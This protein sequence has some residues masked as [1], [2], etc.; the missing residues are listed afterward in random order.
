MRADA[1]GTFAAV[2]LLDAKPK[3]NSLAGV[4]RWMNPNYAYPLP[5]STST[6]HAFWGGFGR[7]FVGEAGSTRLDIAHDQFPSDPTV[8]SWIEDQVRSIVDRAAIAR[9]C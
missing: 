9:S 4:L 8:Q 3:W 6:F 7:P 1:G 2:V 5:R